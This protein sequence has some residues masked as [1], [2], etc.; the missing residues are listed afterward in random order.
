FSISMDYFTPDV[1][2]AIRSVQQ[3]EESLDNL[4]KQKEIIKQMEDVY[5]QYSN[6][7]KKNV[8]RD[9]FSKNFPISSLY[10]HY[11][12]LADTILQFAPKESQYYINVKKIER[13]IN[14]MDLKAINNA[15]I[16]CSSILVALRNA[17]IKG[18]LYTVE[19]QINAGIFVD[20]LEMAEQFLEY[21]DQYIHPAAFLIGGV[22]EEHL[23]KLAIKNDI[24]ITKENEK[25]RKAEE[26]NTELRNNGV[27]DLNEQK[28]ITSWLGL[29]NDA[30][31][32]HWDNYSKEKVQV[33][34]MDVKRIIKQ[35]PA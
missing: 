4:E 19:E 6:F 15:T 34:L 28:S 10:L 20:F 27:Y 16:F 12:A 17:Y 14:L 32:A 35:Y 31:H 8:N 7:T 18:Y 25:Y 9:I 23:R 5:N 30:D 24:L 22:L 21:G 11:T 1:G 2:P 26:L 3:V 29:R 13:E 33:M